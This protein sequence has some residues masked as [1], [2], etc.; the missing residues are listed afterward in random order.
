[1]VGVKPLDAAHRAAVDKAGGAG[2]GAA[3][4]ALAVP[5]PQQQRPY[6]L[7]AASGGGALVPLASKSLSQRVWEFVVGC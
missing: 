5:K 2:A 7:A 1:M 4:F 6:T 3:G